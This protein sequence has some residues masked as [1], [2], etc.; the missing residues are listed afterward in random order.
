MQINFNVNNKHS[1]YR[2]DI[3]GL[4]AIAVLSVVG[5]H[6]F[7]NWVVG[8]FI[9][10]DIFFVISGFLI[11][12]LLIESFSTKQFSYKYFYSRRIIRIF[13]ALILVL[14]ACLIAGWFLLLANEYAVL[15]KHIVAGSFF[16]SNLLL[17]NEKSYFDNASDIKPLLHLWSLGIEEQF[18]I[19]FPAILW[20][21]FKLKNKSYLLISIILIF[22]FIYNILD[23]QFNP[24]EIFYSPFSRAWELLSG[25]LIAYWFV[26]KNNHSASFLSS[27]AS[28][29]TSVIG[30]LLII[31]GVLI[32]TSD[33]LFPGAWA[34]LPVVGTL[35]LITSGNSAWINN[36][37]LSHPLLVWVGLISYP[38]YLW[39]WPLLAFIRI[40]C[41]GEPSN[42]VRISIIFVSFVMAWLT[43]KF[44]ETPIRFRNKDNIKIITLTLILLMLIVGFS[45]FI[46]YKKNG[47]INR[48]NG[49]FKN[50]TYADEFIWDLYKTK[51]C[52]Q[53]LGVDANFCLI[54]GNLKNIEM[55]II[56]DSTGNSLAPGFG[57]IFNLKNAGIINIGSWTC[58][59]IEGVNAAA[60]WGKK[61]NCLET[62][63]NGYEYILRTPSIKY[64]VL[65]IFARD[66]KL[67]RLPGDPKINDKDKFELI[68]KMLDVDII[69]LQSAGKKIIVTYDAPFA[70]YSS[71]L[72][73]ERP[74]GLGH[75]SCEIDQKMLIDQYPYIKYF[76]NY[77]INKNV[78][79]FNQSEVLIK[80]N[81]FNF[82]SPD[83]RFLIR[84]THHLTLF[85]SSVMG[86]KLK[87]SHCLN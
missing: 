81:K 84:D 63:K 25:C 26:K 60:M 15:G 17:L 86:T 29:V 68:S 48:D 49:K 27:K 16:S 36:T 20:F 43:Y 40:L 69:K 53:L 38:L 80:N 30:I 12:K 22:S 24:I 8:G 76:E 42:S 2:T 19:F 35:L 44:I 47:F 18:Y 56:G 10:V 33:V 79:I 75:K 50:L 4:R 13:P 64:V 71:K 7:P 46:V 85:G 57:E 67:W 31:I 72:C 65:A 5:Y 61:N 21:C 9:G 58:P 66:L 62:I 3:D 73:I 23:I 55:A 82:R 41:G 32:I 54:T 45:G 34:L 28:N 51:E 74:V 83:G 59:P 1:F 87:E 78:C 6:A 37:F 11:G 52:S 77:F 70:P 14:I 39:H